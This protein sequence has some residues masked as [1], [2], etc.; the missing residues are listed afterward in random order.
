MASVETD[1]SI[2]ASENPPNLVMWN[3]SITPFAVQVLD[4]QMVSPTWESGVTPP[5]F[6]HETLTTARYS[7]HSII[8]SLVLFG[9]HADIFGYGDKTNNSIE[10]NGD[11]CSLIVSAWLYSAG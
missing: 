3:E 6:A 4:L 2:C 11:H 9:D 5:Y 10:N 7:S 1:M 8:F